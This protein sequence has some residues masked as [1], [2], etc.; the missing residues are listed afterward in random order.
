MILLCFSVI[1]ALF[2]SGT[3][4]A[5]TRISEDSIFTEKQELSL[6]N[7]TVAIDPPS[8]FFSPSSLGVFVRSNSPTAIVFY[9]IT[10]NI[11]DSAEP[12]TEENWPVYNRLT[13][14]GGIDVANGYITDDPN[15]LVAFNN[16][17]YIH[18]TTPFGKGRNIRLHYIA[19]D[20]NE[21]RDVWT[22]SPEYISDYIV[23][24]SDRPGA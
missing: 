10:W 20:Y 1:I 3:N 18:L 23:E 7:L 16:T 6:L 21:E 15:T 2:V 17:P 19:V 4:G 11:V 24:N 22:K 12:P 8:G 5:T 13:R 14:F 9:T